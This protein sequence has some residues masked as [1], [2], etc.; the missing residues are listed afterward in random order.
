ML[1]GSQ[2]LTFGKKY[3]EA[4][5]AK[6]ALV[7]GAGVCLPTRPTPPHPHPH[8]PPPNP[9][10]AHA[11][12]PHPQPHPHPQP[13]PHPHSH[14]HLKRKINLLNTQALGNEI[15]KGAAMIGLSTSEGS[16]LIVIDNDFVVTSNLSRQMCFEESDMHAPK[17]DTLCHKV[18]SFF[19]SRSRCKY[20]LTYLHHYSTRMQFLL[21]YNLGLSQS[22]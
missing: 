3:Q 14:P 18:N 15:V 7:V 21:T 11:H 5:A 2:I 17:A 13:Q 8:P 9:P 4:L 19:N 12:A 22:T 1:Y 16:S 20:F 6:S 10:H